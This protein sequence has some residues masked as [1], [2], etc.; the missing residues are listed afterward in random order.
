MAKLEQAFDSTQHEPLGDFTPLPAAWYTMQIVES[1]VKETKAKDGKYI[2]L[3]LEVMDGEYKGRKIFTNINIINKNPVA[4]E[5][6]EKTL[7]SICQACGK[8]KVQDTV[9]LHGIPMSV[10]LKIKKAQGDY[11]AGN[12]PNGFKPLG[13]VAKGNPATGKA[14]VKTGKSTAKAT[15]PATKTREKVEVDEDTANAWG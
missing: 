8:L 13:G 4:V 11:P 5:I 12:E 3:K 15:K 10:S 6:A 9:V 14:P 1:D 7:T 2:S